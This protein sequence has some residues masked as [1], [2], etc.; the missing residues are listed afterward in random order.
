MEVDGIFLS[1]EARN[2]IR[3]ALYKIRKAFQSFKRQGP[4]LFL[5]IPQEP[6]LQMTD[7]AFRGDRVPIVKG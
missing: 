6:L 3:F 2:G 4:S 7:K 5:V 1:K